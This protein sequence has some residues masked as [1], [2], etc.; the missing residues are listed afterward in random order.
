[1][2][3]SVVLF[4]YLGN[5]FGVSWESIGTALSCSFFVLVAVIDVK[6]RLVLNIL[7]YPVAG[8]ALACHLFSPDREALMALL[9]AVMG[10]ALFFL[11]A[12]AN[13]GGLGGGDVKLAALIGLM[14]GFP[15]VLWALALGILAGGVAAIAL[16]IHPRWSGKSTIPYAP[17]LCLGAIVALLYDPLASIF[18]V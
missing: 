5:R 17:F 13:P 7:V 1:M 11:A 18:R 8:V 3:L 6:Y 12:L 2:V 16:I 4:T 10:F 15:Q 14:V 9:G